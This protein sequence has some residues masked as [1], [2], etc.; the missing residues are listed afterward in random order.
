MTAM[1]KQTANQAVVTVGS[2]MQSAHAQAAMLKRDEAFRGVDVVAVTAGSRGFLSALAT[3][4][5]R[6]MRS[7]V[8]DVY[9]RPVTVSWLLDPQGTAFIDAAQLVVP[10]P[11]HQ[12]ANVREVAT[13]YG[14]G[15]LLDR[16]RQV[17]ARRVILGCDSFP[18]ADVASGAANACGA[19]FYVAD[20]SGLKIG[21]NELHKLTEVTV[22][23]LKR[24]PSLVVMCDTTNALSTVTAADDA[25][26]VFAS[27]LAPFA[28]QVTPDMA[29][30]G[31]YDGLAFGL[32]A[33]FGATLVDAHVFGVQL[34]DPSHNESRRRVLV[35][36]P[37]QLARVRGAYPDQTATHVCDVIEGAN[38]QVIASIR[39]RLEG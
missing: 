21:A 25:R 5:H 10:K 26:R 35:G 33:V 7:E 3:P 11:M 2:A 39:A 28:H 27:K 19:R 9:G 36:S 22:E 17:G 23:Q 6:W 31:A 4:A 8:A 32:A 38:R 20:R 1:H 30:T 15:Q 29:R 24:P 12:D 18:G 37:D 14:L 13:S 16:A 34:D